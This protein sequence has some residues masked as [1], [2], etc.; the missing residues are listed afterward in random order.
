MWHLHIGSCFTPGHHHPFPSAC[1]GMRSHC[2]GLV[3]P[4][5]SP[6][7]VAMCLPWCG[8]SGLLC[9]CEIVMQLQP[10]G[11]TWIYT[12]C[13]YVLRD[14]MSFYVHSLGGVVS[15]GFNVTFSCC[16]RTVQSNYFLFFFCLRNFFFNL[17][18]YWG[19]LE[20]E[21]QTPEDGCTRGLG[22]LTLSSGQKG[23]QKARDTAWGTEGPC[24]DAVRFRLSLILGERGFILSPALPSCALKVTSMGGWHNPGPC[25]QGSWPHVTIVVECWYWPS[26]T[27]FLVRLQQL[28]SLHPH[29]ASSGLLRSIPRD[30]CA[31]SITCVPWP[32][33]CRD[34]FV[35]KENFMN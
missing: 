29:V 1:A 23:K 26:W 31:C 21:T 9:V 7:L 3:S 28:V 5:P 8:E 12:L 10:L 4:L 14:L 33:K 6:K 30:S 34:P 16:W 35:P 22:I 18:F 20:K 2:H 19:R 24:G 15:L 11:G 25:T 32:N 27:H 13:I 17:K